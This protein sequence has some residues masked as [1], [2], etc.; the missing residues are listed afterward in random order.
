MR[1]LASYVKPYLAQILIAIALLFLQANCDLA[2][3]DYMSQIVNVGIQQGGVENAIPQAIRQSEMNRALLFVGAADQDWL[4]S[5][6]TLTTSQSPDYA[7]EVKTY[8]QLAKEPVYIL[9]KVS[10]ADVSRL[11][12]LMGKALLAVSGIEQAVANPALARQ[13]A[14]AG[15]FDLSKLPAGTDV[16]ALLG[17]QPAA[18]RSRITG[19]ISQKFA[20]M[21]ESTIIQAAA[22]PV[23]REYAAL[24]VDTNALQ[25]GYM[26]HTGFIM[27]LITLLSVTCVIL[28]S[29]LASRVAAG[30]ARDVRREV[31]K[32]VEGFSGVEFDTF[33]T[34]SLITRSTND[35][36]QIQMVSMLLMRMVVLAISW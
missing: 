27:L 25:T 5:H 36:T 1:K 12:L 7:T 3:P 17:S 29:L 2:L 26:L 10:S 31:F 6:Y 13:M 9:N 33:S 8:P 20:T 22:S 4:L 14:A 34:A 19:L 16:F 18:E 24:G 21:D 23:Q 32:Q 11:D 15:G 35:I 30:L 28:V